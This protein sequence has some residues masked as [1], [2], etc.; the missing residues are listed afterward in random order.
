MFN[1]IAFFISIISII[2][3]LIIIPVFA[4]IFL[5]KCMKFAQNF[6]VWYLVGSIFLWAC[7]QLILVPL[8][9]MQASFYLALFLV[10]ALYFLAGVIGFFQFFID[11][12]PLQNSMTGVSLNLKNLLNKY[13][14]TGL[15]TF[16]V[17]CILIFLVSI[18]QG[19]TYSDVHYIVSASD[20][21]KSGKMY[22]SNPASGIVQRYF[23]GSYLT[24]LTSPWTFQYAF[25]SVV[26]LTKPIIAAHLIIP[27]QII[28]LCTCI[29]QL[30]AKHYFVNNSFLSQVF[31]C[32][33]WIIQVLGCY[34]N[35]CSEAGLM[36]HSWTPYSVVAS[37]GLPLIIYVFFLIDR[38]PE[39]RSYYFTLAVVN[40]AL[41][42]MHGTGMILG[43]ISVLA[44]AICYSVQKK[45]LFII[46]GSCISIIPNLIFWIISTRNMALS[47]GRAD[48]RNSF[49]FDK[50]INSLRLYTGNRLII[51]MGMLSLVFLYITSRKQTRKLI[52]PVLLSIV[53]AFVLMLTGFLPDGM[54][55]HGIYWLFPEGLL[56]TATFTK[57]IKRTSKKMDRGV[58]YGILVVLLMI[59]GSP[60][61][62][63]C[64]LHYIE[65]LQ[66]I[67]GRCKKIYDYILNREAVP[68]CI[69]CDEYIWAARQYSEDFVL[70][71][72]YN[73]DGSLTFAF[74]ND[75]SL[76]RTMQRNFPVSI[77]ICRHASLSKS[78]YIVIKAKHH[79]QFRYLKKYGYYA[80]NR[81]GDTIIYSYISPNQVAKL[82][83]LSKQ[84]HL[85][86][87]GFFKALRR[88]DSRRLKAIDHKGNE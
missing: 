70:P 8:I 2:L 24:D 6:Y 3:F 48:N 72:A 32:L 16:G 23:C 50:M 46:K 39:R 67:D 88:M 77:F 69:F 51:I 28:I 63:A 82:D 59:S 62:K 36:S 20:M 26:T 68:S 79:L 47:A 7:C 55:L 85:G 9:T 21:L 17:T 10:I 15:L 45:S 84:L 4:G 74:A 75:Q 80:L 30:Y 12:G 37:V 29:Y 53:M 43:V 40:L 33:M 76:P 27:I 57:L 86:R 5:S 71:Y 1:P 52:R 87:S 19:T 31:F 56:I 38:E 35:Y 18:Y 34:S 11:A 44:F 83:Y 81:I 41:C 49:V 42:Y 61:Y 78:N 64:K 66:K 73:E 60:F 54:E 25:L 58:V 22:L 14:I 65:N 13:Q